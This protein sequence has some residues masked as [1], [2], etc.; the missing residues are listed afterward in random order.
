MGLVKEKNND[1]V[2]KKDIFYYIIYYSCVF[3][4]KMYGVNISKLYDPFF[5]NGG[6]KRTEQLCC[7]FVELKKEIVLTVLTSLL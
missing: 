7:G 2:L 3:F 5:K 4:S 6:H 1:S